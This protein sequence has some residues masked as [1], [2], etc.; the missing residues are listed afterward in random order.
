MYL[1]DDPQY[2]VAQN[3]MQW[4]QKHALIFQELESRSCHGYK[5]MILAT[6]TTVKKLP[7]TPA[8]PNGSGGNVSPSPMRSSALPGTM[9][10]NGPQ[11]PFINGSFST[12]HLGISIR[13]AAVPCMVTAICL[14]AKRPA[15]L[16]MN[17][18][19]PATLVDGFPIT[20]YRF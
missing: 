12:R 4:A 8:T 17:T 19:M 7:I 15:V 20:P 6:S 10:G 3:P 5:V 9:L 14:G 13:P 2:R 18:Q 1:N 11:A 16:G